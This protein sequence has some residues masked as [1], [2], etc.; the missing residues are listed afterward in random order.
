MAQ[1]TTR[2]R[3]E[4]TLP[5]DEKIFLEVSNLLKNVDIETTSRKKFIAT[6]S[7]KLGGV[8]LRPKKEFIKSAI[9]E[10]ID[11]VNRGD[12]EPIS[13]NDNDHDGHHHQTS[14][15]E[16][17]DNHGNGSSQSL[18]KWI[19]GKTLPSTDARINIWSLNG[20]GEPVFTGGM[21]SS[22]E[23]ETLK[24]TVEN[25]CSSKNLTLSQLCGGHD[26]VIHNAEARGAWAE[27]SKCLP[28][29]TVVSVYRR[30]LRQFNGYT[31]GPWSDHEV[32]KLFQ[33]VELHGNQWSTIQDMLGRSA[34]DCRWKFED[35]QKSYETG[36]WSSESVKLLLKS[37][38]QL[39]QIS[40]Q[41]MDVREIN[42]WTLWHDMKIPWTTISHKVKRRRKDCYF[43]W[44]QMTKRSNQQAEELGLSPIPMAATKL[45]IDVRAEY[46]RWKAEQSRSSKWRKR[47]AEECITTQL[48]SNSDDRVDHQRARDILLLDSLIQSRATRPSEVLWQTIVHG[49]G[50]EGKSSNVRWEEL[51]D[52]YAAD[53]DMDVPLWKLAK[54]VKSSLLK[55]PRKVD[56]EST[57]I[58]SMKKSSGD[59]NAEM[60]VTARQKKKAKTKH[61]EKPLAKKDDPVGAKT[62]HENKSSLQNTMSSVP[63]PSDITNI[64]NFEKR[65]KKKRRKKS[66]NKSKN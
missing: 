14:D 61:D 66:T 58:G 36:P 65:K 13:D 47:Y 1:R 26:Y 19:K 45:K 29:R 41:E 55:A 33:L 39:L 64:Q 31:K 49:E 48:H 53:D 27:I 20:F 62:P 57:D 43:K 7:S 42:E 32:E 5:S 3:P 63:A 4:A 11:Y 38:R 40:K 52:E 12:D 22:D 15:D 10:A 9:A 2:R 37:V 51:V 28:H 17:I 24:K 50:I 21:Y 56:N 34:V 35:A 54:S 18:C 59:E 60:S 23:S 30:A 44:K 25:Y 16:T 6:L 46:F 8:D